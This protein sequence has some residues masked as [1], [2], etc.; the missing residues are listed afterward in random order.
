MCAQGVWI[1]WFAWLGVLVAVIAILE[2]RHQLF[3][4]IPTP[5]GKA[6]QLANVN[7]D[8]ASLPQHGDG[9]QKHV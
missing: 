5:T 2:L 1:A 7:V 8:P 9:A 3:S 4:S 6:A